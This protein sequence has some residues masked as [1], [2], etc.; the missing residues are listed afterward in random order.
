VGAILG[1]PELRQGLTDRLATLTPEQRAAVRT[2]V[3]ERLPDE[4]R[5][6]LAD[7]LAERLEMLT[8]EQRNDVRAAIGARLAAEVREGLSDRLSEKIG[9]LRERS[10]G[11][12]ITMEQ[13]SGEIRGRAA[14]RLATLTPEQRAA[15]RSVVRERAAL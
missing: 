10:P 2:I 1:S 7:R 3:R 15:V 5:E 9:D 11:S 13:V 14:D 8:P 4:L 6:K 12:G